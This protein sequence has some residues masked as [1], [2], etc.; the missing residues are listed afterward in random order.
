MDALSSARRRP[1]LP[2]WAVREGGLLVI[3]LLLLLFVVY[4]LGMLLQRAV[5]DN[6]AL[7]FND[8]VD[9]ILTASA[10]SRGCSTRMQPWLMRRLSR[11]NRFLDGVSCR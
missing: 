9:S 8:R 7:S 6:G 5:F 3:W 2:D 4:P 1:A 10:S 11:L